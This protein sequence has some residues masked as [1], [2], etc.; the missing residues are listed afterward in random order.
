MLRYEQ[1]STLDNAYDALIN[2]ITDAA[3]DH[4]SIAD[5]LSSQVVEVLRAVEQRSDDAKKKV[6]YSA[7]LK[8]QNLS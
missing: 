5:A 7:L 8:S 6:A 1:L 3:Q 2:S 4:L